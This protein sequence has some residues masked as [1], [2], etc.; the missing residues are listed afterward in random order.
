MA[1]KNKYNVDEVTRMLGHKPDCRVDVRQK[2][3]TTLEKPRTMGNNSWGRVDY[4]T[5]HCGFVHST[6]NSFKKRQ[7]AVR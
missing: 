4:L 3:V 7:H 6:V 2:T 5:R 1:R